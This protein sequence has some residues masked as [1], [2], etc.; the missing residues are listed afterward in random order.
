MARNL[1]K[2]ERTVNIKN[3][4]NIKNGEDLPEPQQE[5]LLLR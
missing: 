2:Y 4:K 3:L 1:P 5:L